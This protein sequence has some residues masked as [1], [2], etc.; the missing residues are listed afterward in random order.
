MSNIVNIKVVSEYFTH[1]NEVTLI[2]LFVLSVI[3]F[4]YYLSLDFDDFLIFLNISCIFKSLELNQ[5]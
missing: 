4:I 1:Y 3:I 2:I 5:L